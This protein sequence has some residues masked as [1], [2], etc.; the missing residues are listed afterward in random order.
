[1]GPPLVVVLDS[2]VLVSALGWRGAPHEVYSLCRSGRLRL[3]TSPPLL[4]ELERVLGYP[5]F[6][7][8]DPEIT[9]FLSDV[10]AHGEVTRPTVE[11]DLIPEDPDDNR[12]LEC[13]VAANADWIVSGDEHLLAP[14]QH[15]N[16]RIGAARALLNWLEG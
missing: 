10:L 9:N 5:K 15:E 14:G 8:T 11:V 7:F 16:V 2:N 6:E 1:M 3:H 4:R 12:I 13:A